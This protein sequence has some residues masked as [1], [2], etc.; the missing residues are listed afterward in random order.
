MMRP[1]HVMAT[2]AGLA[3]I[4]LGLGEEHSNGRNSEKASTEVLVTYQ[5]EADHTHREFVEAWP[6][7][8]GV[9]MPATE[10]GNQIECF[11][12]GAEA[13]VTP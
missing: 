4:G 7:S 9:L 13:E 12:P 11:L 10:A 2:V 1:W 3:L 5:C 6:D 8:R